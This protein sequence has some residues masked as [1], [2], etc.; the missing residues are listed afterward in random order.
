MNTFLNLNQVH[1]NNVFFA[2]LYLLLSFC[3]VPTAEAA[4]PYGIHG[5]TDRITSIDGDDFSCADPNDVALT[6]EV[7]DTS[8][9]ATT[10]VASAIIAVFDKTGP[11]RVY[12]AHAEGA[13]PRIGPVCYNPDTDSVSYDVD[14]GSRF[15]NFYASFFDRNP[16]QTP[17]QKAMTGTVWVT[18]TKTNLLAREYL[19]RFPPSYSVGMLGASYSYSSLSEPYPY[20]FTN[21]TFIKSSYYG[22]LVTNVN[23]EYKYLV[24]HLHDAYGADA[25]SEVDFYLVN[26]DPL[27]GNY[28]TVVANK[29]IPQSGGVG[30]R[31]IPAEPSLADGWYGWSLYL[32]LNKDHQISENYYSTNVPMSGFLGLQAPFLLD[33]TSPDLIS[34]THTPQSPAPTNTVAVSAVVTDPLSGVTKIEVYVDGLVNK[35]CNFAAVSNASCSTSIG[36]FAEDSTHLYFVRTTDLAGNISTSSVRSFIVMPTSC[37][38][39]FV[40]DGNSCEPI[41][42]SPLTCADNTTVVMDSI[43]AWNGSWAGTPQAV[44]K[45]GNTIYVGASGAD[46][47]YGLYIFD[48]SNPEDIIQQ[49]FF[50][51]HNPV[52]VRNNSWGNDVLGIDVIGDYAY[53]ATYYG[54]LVIVDVSNPSTPTFVGKVPLY[55]LNPPGSKET[56][57][58]EVSGN[59][60]FLASGKGIVVVDVENKTNPIVVA[61]L[62]LGTNT[63]QDIIISGNYAYVAMRDDGFSIV[64]I[65]APTNPVEIVH[66]SAG[67]DVN[68]WAYALEKK[69]EILYVGDHLSESIDIY[70]VAN[71][72][73][74][75][76]VD[77]VAVPI[78]ENDSSPRELYVEGD[79]LY[80]SASLGGVY[81][82]DITN[83][84]LPIQY[85]QVPKP[86]L[87]S[88][89]IIWGVVPL[90]G[91]NPSELVLI[92]E[93]LQAG[94]YTT[95]TLCDQKQ[96][97]YSVNVMPTDGDLYL[98]REAVSFSGNVIN[99]TTAPVTEGGWADLEI[100]WNSDGGP[101]SDGGL[102]FD[103]NFNAFGGVKLGSFAKG[104][105]KALSYTFPTGSMPVGMH[106]Y[107]FNVDT[108]NTGVPDEGDEFNNR[109]PWI[110]FIIENASC[111]SDETMD[112][113]VGN[114]SCSG[115]SNNVRLPGESEIITDSLADPAVGMAAYSCK[116][117]ATWDSTPGAAT[118]ATPL[119]PETPIDINVSFDRELIRIGSITMVTVGVDVGVEASCTI[120]GADKS[121]ITFT[122]SGNPTQQTYSYP[123]RILNTAQIVYVTCS[124]KMATPGIGTGTGEMRIEVVP[125]FREN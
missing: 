5:W 119:P 22:I 88:T 103:V 37:P 117:D 45:V 116:S 19:K 9:N 38:A 94:V 83:P 23:P 123:T 27:I 52:A 122:H 35:V 65:S 102:G 124:P 21:P 77:S 17:R 56:W 111:P 1:T 64:D 101:Q 82:L 84:V 54:G 10:T 47:A 91:S 13:G 100:D 67:Y 20:D 90:S 74:P 118:C 93:D 120:Y 26:Y 66:Q 28:T 55:G 6:L 106:R 60:A 25:L 115:K 41:H 33:R 16:V 78:V 2:I 75:I 72:T 46:D 105:S 12:V 53:L 99:T 57:D 95:M 89:A 81:V 18:K 4:N 97:L 113:T 92:S 80:V 34:L 8:T 36:P 14:G 48:V 69:G 39:G 63:S 59:Y 7:R 58:V 44:K 62:D 15:R 32:H 73:A 24:S 68:S 87:L 31:T 30:E 96:D 3:I 109:S 104:E 51:T 11:T 85:T 40:W 49:S 50:S 61:N 114:A 29:I 71:P 70:N 121:P 125:E 76:L 108:D 110:T 79:M 86:P 43:Q 112:W 107:R 98:S 42:P